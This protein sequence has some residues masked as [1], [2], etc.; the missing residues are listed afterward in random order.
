MNGVQRYA[1]AV[2]QSTSAS[3]VFLLDA[4]GEIVRQ[5]SKN[6]RQTYPAPGHVEHD[7]AEIWDA[8]LACTREMV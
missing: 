1:V 7:A 6:H 3:K 4:Q 5:F 2:D 8:T